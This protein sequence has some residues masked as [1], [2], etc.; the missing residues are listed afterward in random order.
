MSPVTPYQAMI[1][2]FSILEVY[3]WN[4]WLPGSPDNGK[5]ALDAVKHF[6]KVAMHVTST[7]GFAKQ[8]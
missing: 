4:I 5:R 3:H 7:L 8:P 1:L 6:G 2:S